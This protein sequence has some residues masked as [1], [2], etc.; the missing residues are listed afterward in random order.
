GQHDA[1]ERPLLLLDESEIGQHDIDPGLRLVR[2]RDAEVDHEPLSRIGRAQ[3]VE[4]DVHPDLAQAPQRHEDE[5][6]LTRR[7]E[8]S[9]LLTHAWTTSCVPRA[10]FPRRTESAAPLPLHLASTAPPIGRALDTSRRR[11]L[12]RYRLKSA[13]PP[14]PRARSRPHEFSRSP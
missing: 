13:G 9:G 1:G 7:A 2:K 12:T 5:L 4:V 10:G 11:V 14:A 8:A 6:A 3:P